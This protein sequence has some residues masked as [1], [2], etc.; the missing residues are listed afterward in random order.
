MVWDIIWLF[1]SS[2]L[3]TIIFI[4]SL[5]SRSWCGET[6]RIGLQIIILGIHQMLISQILSIWIIQIVVSVMDLPLNRGDILLTLL[7]ESRIVWIS[8]C[9]NRCRQWI[10]L[11][12][13]WARDKII[14]PGS[15][16][17]LH[18]LWF[19]CILLV[20]PILT[21]NMP[22]LI[23]TIL[24]ILV[25]ITWPYLLFDNFTFFLLILIVLFF[26]KTLIEWQ[27]VLLGFRFGNGSRIILSFLFLDLSLKL[28]LPFLSQVL[29]IL[30]R[31]HRIQLVYGFHILVK[32]LAG[33]IK[34]RS[35]TGS[36]TIRVKRLGRIWWHL[37]RSLIWW[38]WYRCDLFKVVVFYSVH[39]SVEIR[40]RIKV[41]EFFQQIIL[42]L[43]E[44]HRSYGWKEELIDIMKKMMDLH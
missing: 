36:C 18:I 23:C 4:L 29:L 41:N 34:R 3:L 44:I 16:M 12:N 32:G 6:C 37:I 24:L 17:I 7:R 15:P 8:N 11:N 26:N 10:S 28:N 40:S 31:S 38:L 42:R 14:K 9:T 20:V 35:T 1:G 27:G 39:K 5:L 19:Q 30:G 22:S 21:K 2:I 25:P 43:C 13:W 33:L